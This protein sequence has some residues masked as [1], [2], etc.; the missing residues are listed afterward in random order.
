MPYPGPRR[1]QL[2][3]LLPRRP[4]RPILMLPAHGKMRTTDCTQRANSSFPPPPAGHATL[5]KNR[6]CK[7][8]PEVGIEAFNS[9]SNDDK[10]DAERI[11]KCER[12]LLWTISCSLTPSST[13]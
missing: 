5:P 13:P 6:T 3:S 9:T 1:L 4:L 12:H 10:S 7:A 11:G 2:S 8:H